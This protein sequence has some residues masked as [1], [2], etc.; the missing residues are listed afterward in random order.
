MHAC[1]GLFY[2]VGHVSI[3]YL[4]CRICTHFHYAVG[5]GNLTVYALFTKIYIY[6]YW[7]MDGD[8]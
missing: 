4:A 3:G 6:I 1:T 8:R 2:S 5:Q 7:Y